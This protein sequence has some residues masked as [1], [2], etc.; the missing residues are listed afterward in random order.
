MLFPK[1]ALFLPLL[2]FTASAE[3]PPPLFRLHGVNYDIR[4]G[5]GWTTGSERCKPYDRMVAELS[6]LKQELTDNIRIY[7]M[8]DC[9]DA[10]L[11]LKAT[12]ETGMDGEYHMV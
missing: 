8:I 9:N 1:S 11:M 3:S 2:L 5:P 4:S 10:E 7:S 12:A 6:Q